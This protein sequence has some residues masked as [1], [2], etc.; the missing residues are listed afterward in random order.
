MIA[1]LSRTGNVKHIVYQ[2]NLPSIEITDGLLIQEP[3]VV[4]TYT[5]G[6]GDVPVKVEQFME[7]NYTNCIGVIASGNRNFGLK[8][9][10]AAD[11]LATRYNIPI[12]AKLDL[13]GQS[14]DFEN[15]NNF[16]TLV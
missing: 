10:F 7:R 15:I 8:F 11:V 16:F 3:F 5:D 4:C 2:L 12:I 14:S 9:A 6:L 13:R 1:Y